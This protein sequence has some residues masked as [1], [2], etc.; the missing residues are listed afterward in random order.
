MEAI[1]TTY[2]NE[3]PTVRPG[4][5]IPCPAPVLDSG[6]YEVAVVP[7]VADE[8]FRNDES[9]KAYARFCSNMDTLKSNNPELWE[10]KWLAAMKL[11]ELITASL[12]K[13]SR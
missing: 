1:D 7:F 12:E 6:V 13:V 3:H 5:T 4:D 8:L 9:V 11:V 2:D 10:E